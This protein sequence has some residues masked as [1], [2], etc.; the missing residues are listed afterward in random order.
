MPQT[1]NTGP[2]I[3]LPLCVPHF[4]LSQKNPHNVVPP[5]PS[6][7]CMAAVYRSQYPAATGGPALS[8][9]GPRSV[10]TSS[11]SFHWISGVASQS[12][13]AHRSCL[14]FFC[15]QADGVPYASDHDEMDIAGDNDFAFSLSRCLVEAIEGT[16][17][18][19]YFLRCPSCQHCQV[20][21]S[22][23][24]DSV[25]RHQCWPHLLLRSAGRC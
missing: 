9:R 18:G 1:Q 2:V 22:G 4:L 7:Q 21:G 14:P 13:G 24:W 23:Y 11:R 3:V 5:P 12:E 25:P 8:R 17:R 16:Q 20:R 15:E 10:P 6:P 19:S